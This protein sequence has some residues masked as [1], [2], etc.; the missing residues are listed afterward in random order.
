MEILTSQ[1]KH[2]N[3]DKRVVEIR[4]LRTKSELLSISPTQPRTSHSAETG[5]GIMPAARAAH[6]S[7]GP[8]PLHGVWRRG[9]TGLTS[10]L[11]PPWLGPAEPSTVPVAPRR[12]SVVVGPLWENPDAEGVMRR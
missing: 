7:S 3:Q 5:A 8:C 12:P 10:A 11:T 6:P 4:P 9:H 1:I 2:C